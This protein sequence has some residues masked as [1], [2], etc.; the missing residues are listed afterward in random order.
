[1]FINVIPLRASLDTRPLTYSVG[2]IFREK[3]TIGCLV[4]IPY[5]KKEDEG[6]VSHILSE[7]PKSMQHHAIRPIIELVSHIPILAPYQIVMIERIAQKYLLP[8]HRV[9]SFVLTQP[10][11]HRLRKQEFPLKHQDTPHKKNDQHGIFLAQDHIITPRDIIDHIG[12]SWV[13]IVPDDIFLTQWKQEWTDPDT[14]FIAGEATDTRRAQTWIDI[15]NKKYP[16]I[17]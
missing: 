10:I 13:M 7:V 3:I 2:D 11:L 16:R 15:Y 1:M 12:S 4:R 17:V 6:I 5:G 14:Y 8:I 9:A